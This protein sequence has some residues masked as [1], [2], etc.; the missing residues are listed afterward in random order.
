MV[1]FTTSRRDSWEADKVDWAFA[2]ALCFGSLLLEK[3][4]V[5]LSGQDSKR[6]L[7]HKETLFCTAI[8]TVQSMF[9]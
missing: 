4:R 6:G 5:R 9:L 8:K 1:K 3:K 7:F 2:E